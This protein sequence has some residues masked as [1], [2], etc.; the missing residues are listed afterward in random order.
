MYIQN[1]CDRFELEGCSQHQLFC[2]SI[3]D[4]AS[5][6]CFASTPGFNQHYIT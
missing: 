6:V 5:V 4:Y 1:T 3:T 2:K